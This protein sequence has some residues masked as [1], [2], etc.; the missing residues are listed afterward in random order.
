[1]RL[2]HFCTNLSIF[3]HFILHLCLASCMKS[4]TS[5]LYFSGKRNQRSTWC[6]NSLL[7]RRIYNTSEYLCLGSSYQRDK[8]ISTFYFGSNHQFSWISL[9][10]MQRTF[11]PHSEEVVLWIVKV[12]LS[13]WCLRVN[14]KFGGWTSNTLLFQFQISFLSDKLNVWGLI[15]C[16]DIWIPNLD[17][18]HNCLHPT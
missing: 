18:T 9:P 1:M 16:K 8:H 4:I 2:P 17:I 14:M 11:C 10:E 3:T 15:Q 5:S 13:Y 12:H 7:A 6:Q